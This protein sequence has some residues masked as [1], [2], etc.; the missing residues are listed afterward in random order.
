MEKSALERQVMA[1]VARRLLPFMCLCYLAAFI[2]RVNF[3]FAKLSM[4]SDLHLSTAMDSTG[5]GI[6]FVGYSAPGNV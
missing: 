4:L 3:S 6:F 1:K 2:D 5:A